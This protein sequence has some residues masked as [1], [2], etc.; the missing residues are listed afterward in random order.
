[1]VY[2]K[3]TELA[4][5]HHV[6]LRTVL[7]WIEAAKQ[8]KLNLTLYAE[9]EKVFIAN[10][11]DNLAAIERLVESRRKYR[12]TRGLKKVVPQAEFYKLFTSDQ[13]RDIIFN[14]EYNREVLA[15]YSYFGDGAAYWD[16]YTKR[17]RD[18]PEY[19]HFKAAS[20]LFQVNKAYIDMLLSRS[21]KVNLIDIGPGNGFTTKE[22]LQYLIDKGLLGRYIAYDFSSDMVAIAR[23][24]IRQWFGGRVDFVHCQRDI[25]YDRFAD[26]LASD[27]GAATNLVVELA[28]TL[29]NLPS[30]ESALRVIHDS[31]APGDM[32]L[33]VAKLDTETARNYFD[34]S[35]MSTDAEIPPFS[36]QD[37]MMLDLLGID[38]SFY[39]VEIGFDQKKRRRFIRVT[40]KVAVT[41]EFDIFERKKKI[42]FAK[43][44]TIILWYFW[45]ATAREMLGE[46]DRQGFNVVHASET[47]NQQYLLTIAKVKPPTG[48]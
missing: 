44:S 9:G 17:L 35:A 23:E 27:V 25:S 38:E 29:R 12:N 22:Y 37:K 20:K 18:S 3:N 43:D 45:H 47:D 40:L 28:G 1:M 8:G 31:I 6:S 33:Q 15:Q 46:F 11:A 21:K 14:L 36:L 42:E 39:E 41:I 24:N 7:N 26:M 4:N 10:T 2:L 34:F 13:V 16:D 30:V 5:K 32:F 19:S 48:N